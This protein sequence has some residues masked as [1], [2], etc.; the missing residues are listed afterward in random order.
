MGLAT[1]LVRDVANRVAI[2]WAEVVDFDSNCFVGDRITIQVSEDG[3][4]ITG[5]AS[6]SGTLA[7]P[8]AKLSLAESSCEARLRS[9]TGI[10]GSSTVWRV[11]DV[12]GPVL[13]ESHFH[14]AGTT[15]ATTV[16]WGYLSQ[17]DREMFTLFQS[18]LRL[19]CPGRH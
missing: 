13:S 8:G 15:G 7:R 3:K 1:V 18:D 16:I 19:G 12:A 6:R 2:D 5:S 10:H 11:I 4:L 9:S 17:L 14:L